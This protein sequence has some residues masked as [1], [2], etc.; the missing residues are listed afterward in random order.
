MRPDPTIAA[1]PS[2]RVPRDRS[3]G[4]PGL[5][6]ALAL[7]PACSSWSTPAAEGP[8]ALLTAG[9]NFA[10]NGS[11]CTHHQET[12]AVTEWDSVVVRINAAYW[13]VSGHFMEGTPID[14]P[15]VNVWASCN[16]ALRYDGLTLTRFVAPNGAPAEYVT[17]VWHLRWRPLLNRWVASRRYPW[18]D[19]LTVVWLR[20]DPDTKEV[21]WLD[22]RR[23]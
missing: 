22:V 17:E 1:A 15:V 14:T 9:M 23:Q 19:R 2:R 4:Q 18:G 7:S 20:L 16:R 8:A 5:W 12:V 13:P 21:Q 10:A 11:P 6:L 3:S